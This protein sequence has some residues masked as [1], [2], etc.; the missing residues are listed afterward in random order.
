MLYKDVPFLCSDIRT[1]HINI[2][3]GQNLEI[4]YVKL[5]VTKS[6]HWTL[7]NITASPRFLSPKWR[8]HPAIF[9]EM[10]YVFLA[11]VTRATF[12]AHLLLRDLAL[13]L[14]LC[15]IY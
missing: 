13:E 10:L 5:D 8:L 4:F 12:P 1:K 2:L 6:S 15:I 7:H 9:V 14:D 3:H 11:F